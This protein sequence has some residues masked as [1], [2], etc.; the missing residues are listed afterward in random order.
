[1][2]DDFRI[3]D[4]ALSQKEIAYV[5]TNGT[6]VFNLPLLSPLDL[7][8]DDAIDF[9]DFAVLAENWLENQLWP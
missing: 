7:T 6:G 3:Y 1:L 8:Q 5:A 2:I 4:Y 9:M